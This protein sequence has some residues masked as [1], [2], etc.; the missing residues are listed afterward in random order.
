MDLMDT[1]LQ[2]RTLAD[3]HVARNE[4][5]AA[6]GDKHPLLEAWK[7]RGPDRTYS[8]HGLSLDKWSVR[9]DYPGGLSWADHADLDQAVH[10]ALKQTPCDVSDGQPFPSGGPP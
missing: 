5:V 10:E 2:A 3:Q 9:L 8:F 4:L 1:I 7:A 6:M